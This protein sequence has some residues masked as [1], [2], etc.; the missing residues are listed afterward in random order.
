MGDEV[1]KQKPKKRKIKSADLAKMIK[2]MNK[3]LVSRLNKMDSNQSKMLDRLEGLDS[4]IAKV[5]ERQTNEESS[6]KTRHKEAINKINVIEDKISSIE[7][8][9]EVEKDENK[10]EI[11]EIKKNHADE[12]SKY[13]ERLSEN[14]KTI[15]D[16][17][18]E[19]ESIIKNSQNST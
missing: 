16:R 10:H 12:R 6:N 7:N 19:I 15:N 8:Q 1:F 14:V 17:I 3:S 5:E 9:I 18:A 2:K 4:R 11:N 13:D